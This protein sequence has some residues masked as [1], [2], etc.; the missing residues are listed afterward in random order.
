MYLPGWG[1]YTKVWVV[2]ANARLTLTNV[3]VTQFNKSGV[4]LATR[5]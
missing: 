1:F 4:N 3:S 5:L 2:Y